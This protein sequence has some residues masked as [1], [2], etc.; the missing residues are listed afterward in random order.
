MTLRVLDPTLGPEAEEAR[1][2]PPAPSLAGATVG[3]VDNA[4]FNVGQF[5]DYVEDILRTR[6]GAKE[7]I[8]RRKPDTS[9]PVP[10]AMLAE[11]QECD[12]IIAAVGD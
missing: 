6:Y 10:P 2:A 12:V 11:L 3:F 7:F 8:R 4:K 9:R 5:L 1:L